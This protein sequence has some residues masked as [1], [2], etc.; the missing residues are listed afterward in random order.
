MIRRF[1]I[2]DKEALLLL[3]R[4]NVPAYFAPEEEADLDRFL[5]KHGETF[6]VAEEDG[7]IQ[8][9]GGYVVP[10]EGGVGMIAWY[11]V[12]PESHG[13]GW[14]RQLLTKSLEQLYL[15]PRVE[16]IKVRTSQFA[17]RF[18]ARAGFEL[19]RVEKNYWAPGYDLYEMVIQLRR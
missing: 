17:D 2:A 11:F 5:D 9:G 4:R 7:V 13:Q 1:R 14:G 6:F 16:Q 18:F 12:H 3:F 8:G 15:H 10:A 19:Q